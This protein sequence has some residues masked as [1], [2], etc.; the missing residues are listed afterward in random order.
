MCILADLLI[1]DSHKVLLVMFV[2]LSSKLNVN[3]SF[4]L[5][6]RQKQDILDAALCFLRLWQ[7][8]YKLNMYS[9]T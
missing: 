3:L 5:L 2:L 4:G 8:G 9:R 6:I 7:G 1:L